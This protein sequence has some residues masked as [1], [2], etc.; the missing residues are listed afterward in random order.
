[1]VDP[2]HDDAVATI[3]HNDHLQHHP[4]LPFSPKRRRLNGFTPERAIQE[5][6]FKRPYPP[7]APSV[8]H[9]TSQRSTIPPESQHYNRPAFVRPSPAPSEPSE[10]LPETFSPHKRGQKFVPGG[11]AS[12]VQQWVIET[13]EAAV[14]SRKG[15][16]YLLGEEWISRVRIE[17][18][19]G[20]GPF[21]VKGMTSS[22]AAVAML[23]AGAG[24]SADDGGRVFAA[25]SVVGVKAPV[26]ELEMEG[27]NWT[28][29]VDWKILS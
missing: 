27:R 17:E 24:P 5:S 11:L 26:W 13:G 21:T 20:A 9:F 2:E 4:A 12:T 25:A 19:G 16:G 15:Q 28:V 10:P 23:L 8:P 6:T 14:Q 18:I 1:M 29:A 7:A 3:E 22:G